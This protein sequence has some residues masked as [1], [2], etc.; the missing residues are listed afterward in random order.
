MRHVSLERNLNLD[1]ENPRE[2]EIFS[3]AYDEGKQA[4]YDRLEDCTGS[5]GPRL[6]YRLAQA[7]A[8]HM[9]IDESV[10]HVMLDIARVLVAMRV[11]Q[12]TPA[13]EWAPDACPLLWSESG[14][15]T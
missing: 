13:D 6:A 7:G 8:A 4:F 1:D 14:M 10:G 15:T 11:D 9:Q 2:V 5:N 3:V 12:D